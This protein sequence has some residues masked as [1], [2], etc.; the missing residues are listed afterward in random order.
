MVVMTVA[1]PAAYTLAFKVSESTRRWAVF[2][3]IIPFFTSYL[4]RIFSWYVILAESGVINAMLSY[5]GQYSSAW[6]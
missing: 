6:R 2:L 1:F 4:V 3:L 5:I